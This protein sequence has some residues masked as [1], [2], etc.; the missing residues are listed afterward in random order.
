MALNFW[1]F[2]CVCFQSPE[3]RKENSPG[4]QP[5][6]RDEQ[7]NRPER[8]SELGSAG[9]EEH[10]VITF[11]GPV[12]FTPNCA[13]SLPR[14]MPSIRFRKT[15]PLEITPGSRPPFQGDS[16]SVRIP[17]AEALGYSLFALRAVEN[18]SPKWSG[19]SGAAR[20][21]PC[22]NFPPATPL[23]RSLAKL[24]NTP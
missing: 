18:A 17:R 21:L 8:A 7:R 16:L 11:D 1:T 2:S 4:L 22:S 24:L 20:Q 15:S 3:G 12:S 14:E 23:Q 5:W 9:N 6:E 13:R 10:V 19:T